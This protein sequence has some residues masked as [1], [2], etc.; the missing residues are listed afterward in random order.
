MSDENARLLMDWKLDR[1]LDTKVTAAIFL[2]SGIKLTGTVLKH[3]SSAVLISSKDDPEGITISKSAIS[4][5]QR[6]N[7]NAQ[8]RKGN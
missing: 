1:L 4:T 2:K 7:E 8:P 5:V 6:H 3:D